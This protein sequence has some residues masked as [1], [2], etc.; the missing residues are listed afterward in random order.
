MKT[1]LKNK[2]GKEKDVVSVLQLLIVRMVQLPFR[3]SNT[4]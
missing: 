3:Y 2:R 1:K 4:Y